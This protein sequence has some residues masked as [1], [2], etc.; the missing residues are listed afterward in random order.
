[1]RIACGGRST[2]GET[3]AD[4]PQEIGPLH[5]G[6]RFDQPV[7]NS[8]FGGTGLAIAYES[9]LSK[10]KPSDFVMIS[11]N[12]T[13]PW[14]RVVEYQIPAGLPPCPN[15]CFVSWV[16]IHQKTHKEGKW[17]TAPVGPWP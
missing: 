6:N 1:M 15:G 3:V 13:S 9:D 17:L 12:A 5:T 16:W 2:R 7:N 4:L 14:K 8:L 10:V 11:I